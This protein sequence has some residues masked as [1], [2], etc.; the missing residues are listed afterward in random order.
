MDKKT[1]KIQFLRGYKYIKCL[2]TILQFYIV[3]TKGV[4]EGGAIILGENQLISL[5]SDVTRFDLRD[6]AVSTSKCDAHI[7]CVSLEDAELQEELQFD[8]P[9]LEELLHLGLGLVELLQDALNVVDGAVV[10]RL[11]AGDGR[12][13]GTETQS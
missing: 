12:V 1:N 5:I 2:P 3:R 7:N 8:L 4:V 10:R 13:P 11:V 6:F 9:L